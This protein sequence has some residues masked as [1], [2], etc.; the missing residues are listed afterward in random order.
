VSLRPVRWLL[1]CA[2]FLA[3]VFLGSHLAGLRETTAW[4]C[5]IDLGLAPSRAEWLGLGLYLVSYMSLV[6]VAP[7]LILA[8]GLLFVYAKV[9]ARREPRG[10]RLAAAAGPTR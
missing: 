1:A 4:L 3:L 8:A 10:S 5:R 2:F 6:L 7:V 9:S